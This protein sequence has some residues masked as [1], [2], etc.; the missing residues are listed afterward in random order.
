ML[1]SQRILGIPIPDLKLPEVLE[2]S[3]HLQRAYRIK[4]LPHDSSMP[5]VITFVF[6]L[7]GKRLF[8]SYRF[9]YQSSVSVLAFNHRRKI[10]AFILEGGTRRRSQRYTRLTSTWKLIK[11]IVALIQCSRP[12]FQYF[13]YPYPVLFISPFHLFYIFPLCSH[14]QTDA[15]FLQ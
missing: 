15:E 12:L 10:V 9:W 3:D 1:S 7:L 13:N 2:T 6:L 8:H 5:V 14:F 11:R 4:Q